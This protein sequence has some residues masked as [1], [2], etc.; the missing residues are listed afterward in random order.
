MYNP[1][2]R[3]TTGDSTRWSYCHIW[4]PA[5]I[6][7][8]KP[9]YS[10]CLLIPK[11]DTCSVEKIRTAIDCAYKEGAE[12]LKGNS[13]ILPPLTAIKT[14]LRD[15]DA[16]HPGEP[17]YAGCWF[18]NANSPFRPKV[19]DKDMNPVL[20]QEEVYSGAYG[21]AAISFY[22]FNNSGNRGIACGLN[23]LMKCREGEPLG[24]RPSAEAMFSDLEE[25]D[26]LLL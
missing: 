16:E 6:N 10:V 21:R 15:G 11:T 20:S 26:P 18:L 1:L 4:E 25:I 17:E 12:K 23:G 2:T 13:R 9:K 19:V 14:P 7:G 22:A 3:V 8:G 24:G 5:A